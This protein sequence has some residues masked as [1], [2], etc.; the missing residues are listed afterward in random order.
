[1]DDAI[2][3]RGDDETGA[4]VSH[5]HRDSNDNMYAVLAGAKRFTLV[6]PTVAHRLHTIHPTMHVNPDGLSEQVR[7]ED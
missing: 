5:M 7:L 1:M 6:A 4:F 2:N 3:G